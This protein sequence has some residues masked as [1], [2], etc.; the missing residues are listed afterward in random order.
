MISQIKGTYGNG[1]TPTIDSFFEPSIPA[2]KPKEASRPKLMSPA[3]A[4]FQEKDDDWGDVEIKPDAMKAPHLPPATSVPSTLYLP[5]E[6]KKEKVEEWDD[7]ELPKNGQLKPK[8]PAPSRA[9]NNE[10]DAD[11][12][13]VDIPSNGSTQPKL[14]VHKA[15]EPND[16]AEDWDLDIPDSKPT[17]VPSTVTNG[18]SRKPQI[19]KLQ[20]SKNKVIVA[21][22][23]EDWDDIQIPSQ[24]LSPNKKPNAIKSDDDTSGL[25]IPEDFASR[26]I[27]KSN[28]GSLSPMLNKTLR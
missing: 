22:D 13:D 7:L 23:D 3:L 2:Q 20:P 24:G 19:M 26:L 11:W 28:S 6:N 25:E 12:D 8:L 5:D 16:E 4:K 15:S 1:S 14:V 27:V 9:S 21:D 18:T 17:L 10:D